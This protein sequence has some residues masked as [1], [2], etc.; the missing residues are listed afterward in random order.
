MKAVEELSLVF[1][2]SFDLAI[3]EGH[4]VNLNPVL[5]QQVLSKLGLVVLDEGSKQD[6]E[7]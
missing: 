1:M 2:N 4:R 5:L 7:S 6:R 3:K